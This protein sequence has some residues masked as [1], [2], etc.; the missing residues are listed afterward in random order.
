MLI[1]DAIFADDTAFLIRL[2]TLS[3]QRSSVQA[4]A[5][6]AGIVHKA[7]MAKGLTPNYGRGKSGSYYT[8][9]VLARALSG[10][11][12]SC[13]MIEGS[14]LK[15]LMLASQSTTVTNTL[16]QPLRPTPPWP[17]KSR[18]AG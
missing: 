18:N 1:T 6:G 17:L 11:E 2:P 14:Q 10:G 7:F 4:L 13:I 16:V 5:L 15:A 12:S 3:D 9:G 8:Y